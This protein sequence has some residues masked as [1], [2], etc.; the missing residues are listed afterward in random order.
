MAK[1][2]GESCSIFTVGPTLTPVDLVDVLQNV[3]YEI[4]IGDE[5]GSG[6]NEVSEDPEPVSRARVITGECLVEDEAH[7]VQLA[8]SANP[9]VAFSLET[10]GNTYAGT[11]LLTRAAHSVRRKA[12]QRS[13][14]TIKVKGTPTVTAP[15]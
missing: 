2:K 10:G 9:V 3:E 12:L 4:S 8:E 13:T 15:A 11:G 7:L 14:F 5:D 6:V 1:L